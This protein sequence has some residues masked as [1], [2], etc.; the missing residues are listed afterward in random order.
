MEKDNKNWMYKF[1]STQQINKA[2]GS[3]DKKIRKFSLLK[4]NRRLREDGEL[5]YASETSRFAKAGVLPKAAWNTILSNGGG[6]ISEKEREVYG[7]L[8][9]KFRDASFE[10]QS[11]LIKSD[12][13]RSEAEKKRS[14]EIIIEL[15]E[16]R[17]E[18]QS[19]EASQ[20]SIFENTAEAKARNRA[21]LWW[22]LNLSYEEIEGKLQPIFTGE[23]FNDKLDGYDFIEESDK[24]DGIFLLEIIRRITYLTTLWFL[25]RIDNENDF[26]VFDKS[27]LNN[28]E[29]D[30][31]VETS[32]PA[33]DAPTT[34]VLPTPMVQT[35]EVKTVESVPESL[36][37]S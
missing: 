35:D 16:I 17:K 26:E 2:D 13:D 3:M 8:L 25:G 28:G 12:G 10:L 6:S 11:I 19:F 31:D 14:D 33:P 20:I 29:E 5:F 30:S 34:P 27:F 7:N 24:E 37:P 23:N 21:I 15:D 9:M 32:A 1:E 4:P 22:V 18:I 36:P